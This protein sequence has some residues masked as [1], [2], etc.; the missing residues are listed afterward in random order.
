M[1]QI[2][3]PCRVLKALLQFASKQQQE[4]KRNEGT[5]ALQAQASPVNNRR[6]G[7][8]AVAGAL[9]L[10]RNPLSAARRCGN[11][12]CPHFSEQCLY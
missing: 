3:S 1:L 4:R 11:E 8:T 5:A 6:K 10:V 7:K 12:Q 2:S 9:C